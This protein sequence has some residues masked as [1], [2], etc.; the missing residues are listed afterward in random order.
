MRLITILHFQDYH[1]IAY[2]PSSQNVKPLLLRLYG[3]N[4]ALIYADDDTL[5]LVIEIPS[6]S[7]VGDRFS[8]D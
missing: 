5:H 6:W 7:M 4:Y 8:N 2:L 3:A 1:M